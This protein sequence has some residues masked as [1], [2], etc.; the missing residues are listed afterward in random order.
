[1]KKIMKSGIALFITIFLLLSIFI[2]TNTIANSINLSQKDKNDV[3]NFNYQDGRFLEKLEWFSPNGELPGTY[4]EYLMSRPIKPAY[5]SQPQNF[6]SN[7]ELLKGSISILVDQDLYSKIDTSLDLYI[8][9][10]QGEGYSVYLQKILGGTPAEIKTWIIERYNVG[11]EGFVFIGD[12]TAAWAEVS[13]SVFPCDLFYMD[14]DGTWLDQ[15]SDGD[16]EVHNSGAGDMGPEVYVGRI[17]AST[18]NYDTE[19]NMVNDYLLKAHDYRIGELTQD[20]RGLEYI[21]EDWYNMDVFLRNVYDDNITRY[22]FGFN[23]TA[24]DYLNQLDLGQHFV[25]VCAHSYSGGHHF[26]TR[27]TESASY[28]HVYVY[29]PY[30]RSGKLLL[31]CDDG[32][33]V[34]LNG[35]NVFTNDRYGDWTSDE[36]EVDVSLN[37]GWNKLLCKISQRGGDQLAS[38]RFTD[39]NYNTYDDLIY[40]VKDPDIS[41]AEGVF[42]SSWLLN[43]FH[44]DI[45]DNFWYYLTTNYLGVDEDT[46]NPV[47][48]EVMGGETWTTFNSGNPYLD[49]NKYSNYANYG[50]C[51]AFVR[52]YAETSTAC[53]LWMGYDDGAR[54]WLN[55]DEV[56]YDNR[57]GVFDVDMTK[58]DVTLQ[59]GENRLLIKISEWAGAHG[60]SARFCQSDGSKIDG[61]TF[62]PEPTPITHIGNWLFNGPYYNPDQSTRLSKDYLGD[63]ENTS[64]NEGDSAP[65]GNWERGVG[66]GCPFNIGKHFDHGGWVL[67]EDIQTRDP[68]VLFYNLFACGP[69]RFTDENYLAG[70]YIFHTTYGLITVASSKS[71][72]MLQFNDFTRPLS[73]QKSI[74]ESFREW[75]DA[76]SP[77]VQW[78][79]E[80]YYGMVVCGDPT[81][82]IIENTHPT[83]PI[84]NG[85]VNG[86]PKIKYDFTINS[87]DNDGDLLYYYVDWGDGMDTDWSGPYS[88]GQDITLSHKWNVQGAYTINVR[89]KDTNSLLSPW[90]TFEMTISRNKIIQNLLLPNFLHNQPKISKIFKLLIQ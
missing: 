43:G 40:Q 63:E 49:M 28:G 27:P 82:F 11:S 64:P 48:G 60:F 72:S 25:Q 90:S 12:I 24:M 47:E 61:L 42:I 3:N 5:F 70:A 77:F 85:P 1:M 53:Q 35:D 67:S 86:K 8:Q 50:A 75:F 13:G 19:E 37:I 73:E 26:G 7:L 23:T 20:W 18:L 4:N 59:S 62:D 79:K 38:V 31:G 76:Q 83:A 16:Y 52:V 10:L 14:L 88:S 66:D 58:F 46:I 57:Y 54:V 32:I 78:E 21:D 2:N 55:G 68:P 39:S 29:S 33:K 87:T 69:G 41:G 36:F 56:L 30:Y 74:G 80:W 17:Y 89:S 84:I 65:L 9:D 34:W 15:D 45:P 71:G 44:Q 22:D 51:Y 81:L 6:K